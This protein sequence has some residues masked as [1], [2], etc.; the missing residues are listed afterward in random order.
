M[1]KLGGSDLQNESAIISSFLR[2][3]WMP[4]NHSLRTQSHTRPMAWKEGL[5]TPE[6]VSG[7]ILGGLSIL[8][9]SSS[10]S[11]ALQVLL[12]KAGSDAPAPQPMGV[13]NN[14][15]C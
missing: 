15:L 4:M 8:P 1:P 14:T 2:I 3:E 10:H 6:E 13:K 11:A 12:G 9:Q 5:R 7:I